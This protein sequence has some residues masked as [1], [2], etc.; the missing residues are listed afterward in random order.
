MYGQQEDTMTGWNLP[1]G[2]STRDLPGNTR[3]EEEAEV[4]Y[5]EIAMQLVEAKLID[6]FTV[7]E[8]WFDKL[9]M[10]IMRKQGEAYG[11]G[12]REGGREERSHQEQLE[13]EKAAEEWQRKKAI[14]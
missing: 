8:E 12:Y 10:F 5:D 14:S 4:A 6:Q 1:P 2:C 7:D 13:I 3:E 9:V 11:E